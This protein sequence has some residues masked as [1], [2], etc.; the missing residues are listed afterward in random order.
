MVDAIIALHLEYKANGLPGKSGPGDT[1]RLAHALRHPDYENSKVILVTTAEKSYFEGVLPCED[2]NIEMLEGTKTCNVAGQ[3][4]LDD[5]SEN[6]HKIGEKRKIKLNGATIIH[7]HIGK[8]LKPPFKEYV[9]N[10]ANGFKAFRQR[11]DSSNPKT[12]KMFWGR[13]KPPGRNKARKKVIAVSLRKLNTAPELNT[14]DWFEDA[15]RGIAKNAGWEVL[16][17][18]DVSGGQHREN[19]YNYNGD[20][21]WTQIV[22]LRENA[23]CALGWNSGG[24]DLA[25]AAGM[26]VLRI[27]E[28]QGSKLVP[29][30]WRWGAKYNSFLASATNIGLAPS[31]MR[32][33]MFCRDIATNSMRAFLK[34]IKK[35]S[36]P[37]HV[38]LP[39]GKALSEDWKIAES[40]LSK[41]TI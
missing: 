4:N 2:G 24:L 6:L 37:K 16:L 1:L 26:P 36:G 18:G 17:F 39:P 14:P 15:I 21:L 3:L 28:F 9:F 34:H 41:Y 30:D 5:L 31:D 22:H 10:L 11:I 12:S 40:Q 13:W 29:Q 32:A 35:L 19:V 20:G 27:G 7:A 25:A 38:V 23:D 8:E 33:D